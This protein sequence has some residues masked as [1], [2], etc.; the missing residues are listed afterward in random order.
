M[1]SA[2]AGLFASL[3]KRRS[4]SAPLKTMTVGVPS[5]L[6]STLASLPVATI[7]IKIVSKQPALEIPG[8]R[9]R[10]GSRISRVTSLARSV[11]AHHSAAG[12]QDTIDPDF[13]GIRSDLA[14]RGIG[15]VGYINNS[16]YNNML[17]A[18]RTTFGQQV[19]NGQKPTFFINNL[20]QLT[21][22]LSRYGIS[23]GQKPRDDQ[24]LSDLP[25]QVG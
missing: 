20:M 25:E 6:R 14:A 9:L 12:L 15:Y 5:L 23:D 11:G 2:L 17:P 8:I 13:A 1:A 10:P 22:G 3:L 19:H 24:L 21:Y 4:S 7:A 16:F 18:E